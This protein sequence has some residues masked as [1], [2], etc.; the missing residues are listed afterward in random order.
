MSFIPDNSKAK[1]LAKPNA[2]T[3]ISH[4]QSTT[5]TI[6][7][8]NK[9]ELDTINNWYGSFTPTISSDVITLPSGYFYYI[10]SATQAYTTGTYSYNHAT[11]F[12]HYDETNSVYTGTIG[13]VV[14]SYTESQQTFSRDSVARLLIDCSSSSINIS[15][16]VQDNS[17]NGHTH[18]NYNAAQYTYAA[19]GRTVIWQLNT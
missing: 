17:G 9:V 18:V 14:S 10:E 4:T 13:S 8:D 12:Q 11:S 19:L 1:S 15:F 7:V 6:T 3:V 5:Q 2:L 16:K